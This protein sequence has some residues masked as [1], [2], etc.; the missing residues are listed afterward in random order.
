MLAKKQILLIYLL[1]TAA[2]LLAFWQVIHC[3]FIN[4]DDP[5]YVTENIHVQNGVTQRQFGGHS[6]PVMTQT[7]IL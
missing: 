2:A 3:D 7:G 4:Y 5:L 6:R 1:L